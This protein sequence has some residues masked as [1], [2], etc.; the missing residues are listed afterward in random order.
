M[1]QWDT[2]A[3]EWRRLKHD[4]LWR[5]HSDAVNRALLSR[6]QPGR[7]FQRLLKTD[8]FDEAVGRG[9]EL[10]LHAQ[11]QTVVG[12]DI[13][14]PTVLAACSEG[15]GISGTAGD[16]RRLPFA[17]GAFDA[18][19]SLSTLDHFRTWDELTVSLAELHR[20]LKDGGQL[21]LTIDNRINPVVGLRN[22]LP[23]H[24]LRKLNLVPYYVGTTCGPQKLCRAL[25]KIGFGVLEVTAVLHCPR[26]FAVWLARWLQ[27]KGTPASRE[28]FLLLLMQFESLARLPTRFLTGYFVAVR[29]RR[30]PG[31]QAP[32]RAEAIR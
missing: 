19:V 29:A 26:I 21:M 17:S 2:V 1:G 20:V 15:G 3:V 7:R 24:F 28:R 14:L 10:S 6:G 5:R 27:H 9:L 12:M 32:V 18:V 11:A 8:L 16:V 31:R 30:C 13:S 4:R 22:L 25:D 23:F